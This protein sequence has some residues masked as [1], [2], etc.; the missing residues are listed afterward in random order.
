MLRSA[1]KLLPDPGNRLVGL[2]PFNGH[3]PG[4]KAIPR[5]MG[6]YLGV[7]KSVPSSVFASG[8]EATLMLLREPGYLQKT[9]A[10]FLS[11]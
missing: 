10:T 4:K 2:W 6:R 7:G 11:L 1:D 3:V 8:S 9:E 5:G